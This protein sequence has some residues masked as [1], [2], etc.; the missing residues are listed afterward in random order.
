MKKIILAFLMV[1]ILL[2]SCGTAGNTKSPGTAITTSPSTKELLKQTTTIPL[3]KPESSKVEKIT[4]NSQVL[5]KD[6]NINIYLPAGYSNSDKYSLLRGMDA[7]V[8]KIIQN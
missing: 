4:I 5:K 6:M 7:V 1:S 2:C 8:L 3:Q